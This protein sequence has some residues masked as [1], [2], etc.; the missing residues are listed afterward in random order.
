[1]ARRAVFGALACVLLA[2]AGCADFL[3]QGESGSVAMMPFTSEAHGI[4]G[5]TLLDGS[6]DWAILNQESFSGT[7][8]ELV[9]VVVEQTDLLQLPRSAGTYQGAHL[10]W[11]IF[12]F[13]TRIK[14]AGPDVYHIDLALA[15]GKGDAK[16][17]LVVLIAEPVDWA[18]KPARYR[19]V[20]EHALYAF[21]P[22]QESPVRNAQSPRLGGD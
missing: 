14:G 11:K 21:E 3:P 1:M 18:K 9:A 2:A 7:R 10:T 20:L 12:G 6:V 22:L 13:G 5:N 15:Q 8:E 4:R 19:T 17:Y 16:Q